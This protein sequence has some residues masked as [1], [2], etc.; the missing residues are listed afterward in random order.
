MAVKVLQKK[1]DDWRS[2]EQPSLSEE[3]GKYS[4]LEM[5]Y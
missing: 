4:R 1:Q 3:G 5:I 2:S